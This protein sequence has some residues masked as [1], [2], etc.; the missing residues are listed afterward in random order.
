MSDK[1]LNRIAGLI[2]HAESLPVE[3]AERQTYMDKAI[4][5][6]AVT[7]IDL[8]MARAHQRDK[9]KRETP[10]KKS[11]RVGSYVGASRRVSNNSHWMVDLFS[12]I[13]AVNDVQCTFSSNNVYVHAHGLPSDIAVTEK[14]FNMISTQMV[15]EADALIKRNAH[16]RVQTVRR[17][18]RVEN[19]DYV[20]EWER[21]MLWEGERNDPMFTR[22]T[23]EV[24]DDDEDGNPVYIEKP[25][26]VDGRVW[27]SNFYEGFIARIMS[28]LWEAKRKAAKDAGITRE[29]EDSNEKALVLRDKQGEVQEFFKENTKHV[30]ATWTPPA[31]SRVSIR[32]QETGQKV[33]TTLDLDLTEGVDKTDKREIG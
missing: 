10:E 16:K 15:A 26:G 7:N 12:Q 30:L 5:L 25:V 19:P 24:P 4:T 14:L 13:A 3:S 11:F 28:R 18:K 33:A 32:G 6:A 29:N 9:N 27:R 17:M 22:K 20:P 2:A 23:I 1:M 31:P 21:W 8:A